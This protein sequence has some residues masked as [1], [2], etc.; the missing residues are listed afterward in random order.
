[1]CIDVYYE[2]NT[3]YIGCPLCFV[4]T[5]QG[6]HVRQYSSILGGTHLIANFDWGVSNGRKKG[7]IAILGISRNVQFEPTFR[8]IKI[9]LICSRV[10]TRDITLSPQS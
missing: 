5:K 4:Q 3:T 10:L 1:M 2:K 6:Y 8:E 7:V 9:T